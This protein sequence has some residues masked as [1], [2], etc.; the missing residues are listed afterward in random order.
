M[1]QNFW[2]LI[3]SSFLRINGVLIGVFGILIT[4]F[5]W[6]FSPKV[7]IPLG[8]ALPI[9]IIFIIFMLTLLNVAYESFNLSKR[10]LP[11]V[12]LG[13]KQGAQVLCLLEPSEL[14]SHGTLASFYYIEDFFEQLIGIGTVTNVQEDG[15]IQ[16]TMDIPTEGYEDIVE[17]LQQNDAGVL[18]KIR[19]KPNIP[20]NYYNKS[21]I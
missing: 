6:L 12:L 5:L 20:S 10:I 14:F 11:K 7:N 3:W 15:K 17:K 2:G 18:N 9:L 8:V 13:K 19:V 16:V 21:G 1:G 4:V